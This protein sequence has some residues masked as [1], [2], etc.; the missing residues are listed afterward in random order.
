MQAVAQLRAIITETQCVLQK[1]VKYPL[2]MYFS[3]LLI[4]N[5]KRLLKKC[6]VINELRVE[7]K[8]LRNGSANTNN[9]S[10]ELLWTCIQ[11]VQTFHKFA[12]Q[13]LHCI[14]F[15]SWV[16]FLLCQTFLDFCCTLYRAF[17]SPGWYYL[18]CL[19]FQGS[20]LNMVMFR[21]CLWEWALLLSLSLR[22]GRNRH[23][24]LRYAQHSVPADSVQVCM[25]HK[26]IQGH[27]SYSDK[28]TGLTTEHE[29][30]H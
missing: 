20:D 22:Q 9:A 8:R 13:G 21:K 25:M 5:R 14:I 3:L 10:P 4:L 18:V 7:E 19:L 26:H 29:L 2:C 23:P 16:G 24:A 28:Q 6:L 11:S 1:D 30:L 12:S 17:P 15:G 27:S